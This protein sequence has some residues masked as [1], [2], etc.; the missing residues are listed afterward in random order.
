MMT[1]KYL[2]ELIDAIN[3]HTEPHG[4]GITRPSYGY[5]ES[6]AMLVVASRAKKMDL[7]VHWDHAG[8]LHVVK[9]G[10]EPGVITGSHLDS[11]PNGGK[12]DGVAGVAAGLC[13]MINA[14]TPRQLRL[15]VFRGEESAW[16]GKCY[17]GSTA[18]F[19]EP[20][21]SLRHKD[22]DTL[23]TKLRLLREQGFAEA[24]SA[25]FRPE[26]TLRF[27]EVHI[28]QGPVL[29]KANC[30]IGIVTSIRGNYRYQNCTIT[31]EPGH[32]GT[33]P[34][35]MRK[36]SVMA[37]A[38]LMHHIEESLRLYPHIVATCGV[39][40]TDTVRHAMS[41][42]PDL[43][44]FSFEFRGSNLLAMQEFAS[45]FQNISANIAEARGTSIELGTP[46]ITEPV[47]LDSRLFKKLQVIASR[48][49]ATPHIPSG[50]GHDAAVFQ[51]NGIP[52]GMIFVRNEHGSHN[53]QESMRVEDLLIATEVLRDAMRE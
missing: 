35:N 45:A 5:M 14:N 11:V 39:V 10:T 41:V 4:P 6:K 34:M 46:S 37:F 7:M 47:M 9:P 15:I 32:S 8:N 13:A 29:H 23:A 24:G 33:T 1:I 53:P 2:T 50:A 51:Q 44:K 12:Y 18:L 30:A 19:K 21:L 42:I 28:E 49:T 31:G 20:D 16:F 40:G 43:V 27:L 17:L 36:D 25:S 22:G 52:T 38:C 26:N 3:E 48:Y